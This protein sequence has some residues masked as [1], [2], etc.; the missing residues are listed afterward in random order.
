MT[1]TLHRMGEAENLKGDFVIFTMSAK[2]VNAPGSG[3]KMRQFFE[4]LEK[5]D[6]VNFGDM[7]TGNALNVDR[8]TIYDNIQDTSIVH[9]VFEDKEAVAEI[10]DKLKKAEL[11]TSVVV[12]GL[13]EVTDELCKKAGLKMHTVEFSGGIHGKLELLPDREILEITTMCGHGMVASN[14]A[15]EM[16]MQIKKGKKT[17]KEACLEL[18]KPCQCGVFN[19]KRAAELFKKFM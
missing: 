7:K 6:Y 14:L 18:A 1:H 2:T 13:V 3:A 17:L 11:G 15:R 16:I 19:P 12:S 9:F 8:Q 4:I 10:L 5:Y